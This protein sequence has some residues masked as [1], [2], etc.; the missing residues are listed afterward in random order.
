MTYIDRVIYLNVC[1]VLRERANGLKK[2]VR[3]SKNCKKCLEILQKTCSRPLIIY[4]LGMKRNC[5]LRAI[6][7]FPTMFT[8]DFYSKHVKTRACLGKG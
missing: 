4:L 3:G 1:A 7:P 5:S 6:S 2:V 8:K